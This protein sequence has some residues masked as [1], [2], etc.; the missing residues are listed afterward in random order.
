M[1]VS[2]NIA[3]RVGLWRTCSWLRHLGIDADNVFILEF[4]PTPSSSLPQEPLPPFDCRWSVPDY[5]DEALL[6]RFAAAQPWPQLRFTKAVRLWEQYVDAN[7]SRF[8]KS[9]TQG[10]E[11]FA[12]LPQVWTFMSAF[13]PRRNADGKLRLSRFDEMLLRLLSDQPSTPL[14][15]YAH[16]SN[17]GVEL[18]HWLS[19]TGDLFLDWRLTQWDRHRGA[20]VKRAPGPNPQLPLQKWT[21]LLTDAGRELCNAGLGNLTDAPPL[22]IGGTDAYTLHSPWVLL[23]SGRP[24]SPA[25]PALKTRP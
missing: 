3:E 1:W 24:R 18:R 12:E 21:Y 14:Q 17:L 22:T 4:E 11:R 19:V 9:C 2:T 8:A 15:V 25:P 16:D 23:D 7:P 6:T 13:F 20:F 10:V 5:D